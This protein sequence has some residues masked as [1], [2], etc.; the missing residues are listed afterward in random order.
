[1]GLHRYIC[2][3]WTP[4]PLCLLLSWKIMC[5]CGDFGDGFTSQFPAPHLF[6]WTVIDQWLFSRSKISP[7]NTRKANFITPNT[8]SF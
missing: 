4:S 5:R 8:A 7:Q 6:D 1:M 2:S 3:K